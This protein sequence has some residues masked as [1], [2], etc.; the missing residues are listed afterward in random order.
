MTWSELTG[1]WSFPLQDD[2][3]GIG[4]LAL[5]HDGRTFQSV[6]VPQWDQRIP[7]T[8]HMK[9][10]SPDTIRVRPAK[11]GN[12]EG[13]TIAIALHGD[14]LRLAHGGKEFLCTR[15][16]DD[17]IPAWFLADLERAIAS[18]PS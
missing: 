8:L 4:W 10:E 5:L 18:W 6:Y 16:K 9:L 17:E 7:M 15:A 1:T 12:Q 2:P 13:W 3:H 14:T 11:H